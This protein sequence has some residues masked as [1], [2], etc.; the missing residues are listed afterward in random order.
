MKAAFKIVLILF[1][2]TS[3]QAYATDYVNGKDYVE[4]TGIP[5]LQQPIVREFFPIIVR[6]VIKKTRP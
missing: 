3:G 1:F 4:V 6:I 2:L 5:E